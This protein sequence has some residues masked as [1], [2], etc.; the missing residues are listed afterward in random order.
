MASLERLRSPR[1]QPWARSAPMSRQI[2]L[3]TRRFIVV[4]LRGRRLSQLHSWNAAWF[5]NHPHVI[6]ESSSIPRMQ[7]V[8]TL[9]LRPRRATT[10]RVRSLN[11]AFNLQ[12]SSKCKQ[13][14]SH[15]RW[16]YKQTSPARSMAKRTRRAPT[17]MIATHHAQ[18]QLLIEFL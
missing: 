3:L 6:V 10:I 17:M 7:L 14:K 2:N 13:R 5:Y 8:R 9:S 4:A 18:G 12:R 1:L 16:T 15:R 11:Q